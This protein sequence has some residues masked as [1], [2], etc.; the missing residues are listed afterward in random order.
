MILLNVSEIVFPS[1]GRHIVFGVKCFCTVQHVGTLYMR[2]SVTSR[3]HVIIKCIYASRKTE[4]KT[5]CHKEAVA[6]ILGVLD[7]LC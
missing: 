6:I 3:K 5:A 2:K 4:C 7:C 1:P